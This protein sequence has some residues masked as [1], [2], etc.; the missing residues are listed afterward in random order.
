MSDLLERAIAAPGGDVTGTI[1]NRMNVALYFD[2]S[3][4]A[5]EFWIAVSRKDRQ[6]GFHPDQRV[7]QVFALLERSIGAELC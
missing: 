2:N 3:G 6:G 7:L 5:I 1:A 4:G